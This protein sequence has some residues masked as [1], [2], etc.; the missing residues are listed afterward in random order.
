MLSLH[1][2]TPTLSQYRWGH[3][4]PPQAQLPMARRLP[5][6]KGETEA[7]SFPGPLVP[8]WLGD[9]ECQ[10]PPTGAD[11]DEFK[12]PS[13]QRV[14]EPSKW[15]LAPEFGVHSGTRAYVPY[16]CTSL[17][18][19]SVENTG[20]PPPP[21][22]AEVSRQGSLVVGEKGETVWGPVLRLPN[23]PASNPPPLP[24]IPPAAHGA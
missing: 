19:V 9:L 12:P 14:S 21:T 1:G 10:A 2:D 4:R 23:S 20:A 6:T 24:C 22:R 3:C 16:S 8:A 13:P 15:D 5:V 18:A 11:T 7:G 17:R